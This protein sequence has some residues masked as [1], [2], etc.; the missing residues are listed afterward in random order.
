[1]TA[2]ARLVFGPELLR[3]RFS[4]AHPFHPRRIVLAHDLMIDLGL[5]A[6]GEEVAP[7]P[8]PPGLLE[9]IHDR[10]YVEAVQQAARRGDLPP[11]GERFGLGTPD[12]PV[13]PGMHEAAC[14][15]MGGSLTAARLV[16]DGVVP[17]AFSPGGGLHHALRDR[18]SGFC[19]YN[20]LVGAITELLD[21]GLRVA[22]VD[23]DAHHGDG[24][25]WAFYHDPR[26]LTVSLHE[27]GRY[28]FPGTGWVE[29]RGVGAA[30]GTAVNVPL[31]PHTD[32]ASYVEVFDLVVPAVLE[33][34]GPDVLVSLH[35]A[36]AHYLDPLTHLNL[37]TAAYEHATVRLHQLAH[38][39]SGGR[40]VA[41]GGGGYSPWHAVPRLWS[42]VWAI[43]AHRPLPTRMPPAWLARWQ[44]EA[45]E[46]LSPRFFD[47]PEKAPRVPS[48][49][50][51]RDRNREQA[52]RARELSLLSQRR[53]AEAGQG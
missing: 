9:R 40:W 25:Q 24:V 52:L 37:T 30:V 33:A 10:E 36:D 28:L 3:Y 13:F 51:A 48:A 18:A 44:G 8:C 12:N 46:P 23:I 14:A 22:Y 19:I 1:M 47:D 38:E 16:R 53:Q 27:S 29:E 32:D 7:E 42:L 21:A 43:Q 35:G 20:D 5:V 41:Y 45:P 2:P 39:L 49:V 26:V 31:E 50:A 15:W 17:H 4:D 34:F 6:E 11:G